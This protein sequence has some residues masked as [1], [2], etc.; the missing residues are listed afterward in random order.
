[1][2]KGN[3]HRKKKQKFAEGKPSSQTMAVFPARFSLGNRFV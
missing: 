2:D 3:S 1:M